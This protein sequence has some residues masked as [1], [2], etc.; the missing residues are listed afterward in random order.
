MRYGTDLSGPVYTSE[1]E[2]CGSN[3]KQPLEF[4]LVS[5]A[6]VFVSSRNAPSQERLLTFELL[7]RS[8]A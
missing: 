4:T 2:R 7:G 5:H 1:T 6:A 3:K 8:V